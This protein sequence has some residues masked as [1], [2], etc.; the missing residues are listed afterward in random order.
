MGYNM[1]D[2]I[3]AMVFMIIFIP[4][5]FI[6]ALQIIFDWLENRAFDKEMDEIINR[7]E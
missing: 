5:S 1:I 3:D 7:Q 6:Y 4:L 2:V